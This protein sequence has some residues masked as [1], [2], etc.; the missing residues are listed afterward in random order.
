MPPIQ[1][2][3]RPASFRPT[4]EAYYREMEALTEDMLG[5]FARALNL[6][7]TWFEDKIDRHRSVIRSLF[8]ALAG[9]ACWA[10]APPR[11]A[12]VLPPAGTTLTLRQ[13]RSRA[14]FAHPPTPI[15]RA[16]LP[17]PCLAVHAALTQRWMRPLPCRRRH[18]DD[19]APG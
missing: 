7:P 13:R 16:C 1:W 19:S 11:P 10:G 2:P 5:L 17:I 18:H 3:S 4:Y 6:E 9:L 14:S 12:G 8:V 15:V